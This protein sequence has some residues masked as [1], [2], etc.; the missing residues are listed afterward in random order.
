MT[1]HSARHRKHH[2]YNDE[3]YYGLLEQTGHKKP[4]KIQEKLFGIKEAHK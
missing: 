1:K 2:T 3:P 4:D